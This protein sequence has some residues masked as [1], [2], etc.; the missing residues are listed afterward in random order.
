M[1][2]KF[3]SGAVLAGAVTASVAVSG[4]AAVAATPT[5]TSAAV[6]AQARSQVYVVCDGIDAV[7]GCQYPSYLPYG[8]A[9]SF[10][11]GGSYFAYD[12]PWFGNWWGDNYD[13]YGY[14]RWGHNRWRG[15]GDRHGGGGYHHRHHHH[16]MGGGMGG[17][18]DDD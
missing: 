2:S 1:V 10:Y 7:I 9:G 18:D 6:H 14:G 17:G 8:F 12:Q 4:G 5:T 16:G 11:G 15:G 3:I 13:D